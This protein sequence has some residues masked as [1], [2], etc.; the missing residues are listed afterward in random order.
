[1]QCYCIQESS[2]TNDILQKKIQEDKC[3]STIFDAVVKLKKYVSV[4]A[5]CDRLQKADVSKKKKWPLISQDGSL[6]VCKQETVASSSLAFSPEEET[7]HVQMPT[8]D[9]MHLVQVPA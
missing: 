4:L 2:S 3:S 8:A 6:S 9:V 5:T 1:M 7:C